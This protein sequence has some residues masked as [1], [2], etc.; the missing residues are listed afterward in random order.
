MATAL[1]HTLTGSVYEFDLD[2]RA[3]RRMGNHGGRPPTPNLSSDGTWRDVERIAMHPSQDGIRV[4]ILWG[5]EE[6][7]YRS[8]LLSAALD[9]RELEALTPLLVG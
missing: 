5:S 6:L 3:A 2:A 8:T 9:E 7:A 4:H 1:L